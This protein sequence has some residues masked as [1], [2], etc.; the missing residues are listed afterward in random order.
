MAYNDD[1]SRDDDFEDDAFLEDIDDAEYEADV[2]ED[3][4]DEDAEARLMAA[5]PGGD[6]RPIAYV[7][8]L[9]HDELEGAPQEIRDNA[10]FALLDENGRPLA[11]FRD[12]ASAI[13]MAKYNDFDPMSVH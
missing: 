9:T 10:F 13:V 12:R 5:L 11:L 1:H 2:D 3:E 4:I 8:P 7:R 6:E